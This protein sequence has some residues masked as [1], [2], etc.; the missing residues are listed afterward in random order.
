MK[1]LGFTVIT[2][3]CAATVFA[4]HPSARSYSRMAYDAQRKNTVLYG[5]ESLFDAATQL[6]YDSDETWIWTG[7][8]W[9]QVF[10]VNHPPQRS[11]Q[12]MVYDSLRTRVLL[13]GG[14]HAKTTPTG[15]ISFYNDTWTWNGSDWSELHPANA[16][17]PRQF[18]A[19]A[20]DSA[21]DRVILYGGTRKT[22]DGKSNEGAYDT[23][24]FDGTTWTKIT[25]S[26]PKVNFPQLAYDVKRN[27]TILV[28]VDPAST[29]VATVMY[30]Y[31]PANKSWKKH[32]P[33]KLPGCVN[34]SSMTYRSSIDRVVLVGG[35]C[36]VE[37]PQTDQTWE[38]DGHTWSEA[39]VA[40]FLRATAQAIAYDQLRDAVVLFGGFQAFSTTPRSLTTILQAGAYRI[41][42]DLNR[43]SPRSMAAFRTDPVTNTAW[44]YGGLDELGLGPIDDAD[45]TS[46]TLLRI[47]GY[48]NGYW[49]SLAKDKAPS[50]CLNP[51]AAY[52]T[53]RS[54]LVVVCSGTEVSEFDG[55][56]WTE[57][58]PKDNPPARRF[59]A[60]VYDENIKK[61]VLFGGYDG[62]N[63]R[64]D[65]W[66]WDGTT[67]AEVKKNKPTNRSLMAM[68]YDPLAK[69]TI[70]YGGL[71]RGSIDERITR[72]SDMYSF[73]GSGWTK[74]NVSATP[75]ERFGPQIAVDPRNGK[76][77]LFGGLRSEL[78]T[79]TDTRSQ[80]FDNDTWLWDGGASSWT[81]LNP[82]RAPHAREN[83]SMAYD[84]LRQEIVLFGGYAGFYYSDTWVFNGTT[85]TPRFD[86]PGRVR[87]PDP[88]R[89][90][91]GAPVIGTPE[92]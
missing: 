32:T 52:D 87:S 53:S 78:N 40:N 83:G 45:S 20:Y 68:W 86:A 91:G 12:G 30:L 22:A 47:W 88:N 54:K 72:Y 27:Q 23:W 46:F 11:A 75:G 74:M 73:D 60:M 81:K 69:K 90:G 1:R 31:E 43:P 70:L 3:L 79:S 18:A 29:T 89:P 41:A 51:L 26:E 42:A 61:T 57:I 34:D 10:P 33:D 55:S 67:W 44:L 19:L 39:P 80:F 77:V 62:T 37:T 25:D 15:D 71:G 66:T 50:G 84:P 9:Q 13:F 5:G 35:V 76:L 4:A 82:P 59:A 2:L 6:T 63:Y 16:P 38:W 49:F 65:T 64:N 24:E 17:E 21:R 92:H 7:G 56:N 8:A 28:G 85:W 48:R 36:S 14:R 58:T